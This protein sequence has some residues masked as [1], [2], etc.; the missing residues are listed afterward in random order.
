M[1]DVPAILAVQLAWT[2][3]AAPI[4]LVKVVGTRIP[5]PDGDNWPDV[6][7]R[8]WALRTAVGW[9]I[10]LGVA[11]FVVAVYCRPA[12]PLSLMSLP[13]MAAGLWLTCRS[14]QR[15]DERLL[16]RVSKEGELRYYLLLA[17]EGAT[18]LTGIVGLVLMRWIGAP[19][20]MAAVLVVLVAAFRFHGWILRFT[21]ALR[22][23]PDEL[24]KAVRQAA[25]ELGVPYKNSYV[26]FSG[27]NHVVN[28]FAMPLSGGIVFGRQ[29]VETF[30]RDEFLAVARHELAHLSHVW[31]CWLGPAQVICFWEVIT[32]AAWLGRGLNVMQWLA[33]IAVFYVVLSH[34]TRF[35]ARRLEDDTDELASAGGDNRESLARALIRLHRTG[36]IPVQFRLP[37]S[38]NSLPSRVAALA[39]ALVSEIPQTQ[40]AGQ[41]NW[42][43]PFFLLVLVLVPQAFAYYVLLFE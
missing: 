3:M 36:L 1:N 10:G 31:K 23:L 39:P 22:P 21:G 32:I 11:F 16:G 6:A 13:I 25:G 26:L 41:G 40:A 15:L 17:V 42:I 37:A 8:R 20:A 38:H 19:G 30:P 34:A 2:M 33:C 7:A 9:M 35:I 14:L 27:R 18:G 43:V 29:L 24:E 12:W 28:A 4:L 5:L